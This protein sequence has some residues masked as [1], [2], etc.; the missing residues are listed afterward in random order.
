VLGG[1]AGAPARF[2]LVRDGVERDLNPKSTVD[3]VAG[4]VV[5]CRTCGG[6]GYGPA[7]ERDPAHV[8]RDVREGKV[9]AQRARDVYRVAI[10]TAGHV[11]G[12]ATAALRAESRRRATTVSETDSCQEGRSGQVRSGQSGPRPR[13]LGDANPLQRPD[14][15]ESA[16]TRHEGHLTKNGL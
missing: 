10:G 5:S 14:V 9:S 6:G 16:H 12:V 2:V 3:L 1:E 13:R 11:D 7:A 8:A 15:G 4:D